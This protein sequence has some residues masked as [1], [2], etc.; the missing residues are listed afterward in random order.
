M[1]YQDHYLK[2][3]NPTTGD[4][5][6]NLLSELRVYLSLSEDDSELYEICKKAGE[7]ILKEW[8]ARKINPADKA[9]VTA[10][11]V[12]M[13]LYCY[14]LLALEIDAP[15]YRQEQLVAFVELLKKHGKTKGIDYGS[16]IGTLGIY[17]NKNGISCDFADVSETNLKF[18]AERLHRRGLNQ[19]QLI[20]LTREELPTDQ[21]DF[22]T[23][24]DVI[25]HIAAPLSFIGD[26][27]ARLRNGGLFIFN[28]LGGEDDTPHILRDLNLIRKN[29][30]GFGLTKIGTIGEFKIYQKIKRP[31]FI[32]ELLR[33][34]DSVFW[35]FREKVEALKS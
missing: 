25:E 9:A 16:G 3:L 18:I 1:T 21:Y 22:I 34:A 29:I 32:N 11:Y 8:K 30:R 31:N 5:K 28:L 14:E 24:F 26:A 15:I 7:A 4:L 19:S 27:T 23:A 12:D 13:K 20:N 10:F 2:A 33:G 35:A 17:L 6:K